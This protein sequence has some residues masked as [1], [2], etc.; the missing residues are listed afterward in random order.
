MNTQQKIS[1]QIVS[2]TSFLFFIS[3]SSI[4][5]LGL[6]EKWFYKEGNGEMV[7]YRTIHWNEKRST[8]KSEIIYSNNSKSEYYY[9]SQGSITK[10]VIH[11]DNEVTTFDFNYDNYGNLIESKYSSNQ[12]EDTNYV[13]YLNVLNEKNKAVFK[14]GISNDDTLS[15]IK[16]IYYPNRIDAIEIGNDSTKLRKRTYTENDKIIS[17]VRFDDFGNMKDSNVTVYD[18]GQIIRKA[19]FADKEMISEA[20]YKYEEGILKTVNSRKYEEEKTY[21]VEHE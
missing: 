12:S 21:F 16:L 6:T 14:Y 3:C 15:K 10:Q 13:S 17:I 7:L 20:I 2:I 19:K 11:F 4:S 8:I 1:I 18:G 9:N 5:D